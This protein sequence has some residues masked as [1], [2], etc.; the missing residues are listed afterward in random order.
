MKGLGLGLASRILRTLWLGWTR[1]TDRATLHQKGL[2]FGAHI[3]LAESEPQGLRLVCMA[4]TRDQMQLCS[5][6]I[7]LLITTPP[8]WPKIR[9]P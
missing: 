1:S 4:P 9:G 5:G 3:S 8:V 2:D 6:T 7:V